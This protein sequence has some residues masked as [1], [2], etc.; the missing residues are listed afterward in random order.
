MVRF[1]VVAALTG[2]ILMF[3]IYSAGGQ[4]SSDSMMFQKREEGSLFRLTYGWKGFFP[5]SYRMDVVVLKSDLQSAG[6]EIGYR[7]KDLDDRLEEMLVPLRRKM[8]ERLYSLAVESVRKSPFSSSITLEEKG[9]LE[10]TLRLTSPPELYAEVKSEFSRIMERIAK[11][12][13]LFF[14]QIEKKKWEWMRSYLEEK[15]LRLEGQS[16][17]VDYGA[18]VRRNASRMKDVTRTLRDLNTKKDLSGF[19]SVLLSFVQQISYGIPPLKEDGKDILGFWPPQK[20]L[21]SNQGDCDSKS[22]LSASSDQGASIHVYRTGY[23]VH[24]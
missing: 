14:D 23:S 19:V 10:F 2:L 24:E 7:Q 22:V 3:L 11:E 8:I 5:V 1:R 6:E 13:K 21:V 20:V 12:Q 18:C 9:H 17:S 15:G 4:V 16:V